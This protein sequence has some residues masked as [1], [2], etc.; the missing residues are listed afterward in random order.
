MKN[1]TYKVEFFH[2]KEGIWKPAGGPTFTDREVARLY[3]TGQSKMCDG[4][5]A[6][7]IEEEVA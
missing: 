7:R 6:F 4:M 3:M 1:K 2:G 5:V